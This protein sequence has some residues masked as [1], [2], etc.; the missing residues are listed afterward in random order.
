[1]K[2]VELLYYIVVGII[3][4]IFIAASISK[5]QLPIPTYEFVTKMLHWHH[6]LGLF[7][8][9][10]IPALELVIGIMIL[11]RQRRHIALSLA[12]LISVFFLA[13]AVYVNIRKIDSHCGCF[14]AFDTPWL[15]RTDIHMIFRNLILFVICAAGLILDQRRHLRFFFQQYCVGKLSTE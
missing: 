6:F 8:I 4:F 13:F 15:S 7:A 12:V 5:I 3:C 1:M 2:K 14:G 10:T 11:D 9:T